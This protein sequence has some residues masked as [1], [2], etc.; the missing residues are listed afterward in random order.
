MGRLAAA[1]LGAVIAYLAFV[2]GHVSPWWLA[3]PICMFAWLVFIHERVLG[4]CT[5]CRR[6]IAFYERALARLDG[7]WAGKG[8]GGERFRDETHPYALDLDLFGDGSLFE[9]LSTARLR[10]GE[11]TLAGWLLHPAGPDEVRARQAAVAELRQKLDLRERLALLAADVPRGVDLE[12]LVSWGAAP[13]LTVSSWTRAVAFALPAA[14]VITLVGWLS[15]QLPASW[16]AAML[17]LEIGF[18]LWVGSRIEK[19]L[20]PVERRARDLSLFAGILACL[21]RQQFTAPR[22]RQLHEQFYTE[23]LPPSAR[24][25]RLVRLIHLLDARR[26]QLFAIPAFL[27]LWTTHLAFALEAWRKAAGAAIGRWLREVGEFEA[28]LALSAYA[29]ENPGDPFPEVAAD[30]HCF[31]GEGLGHPLLPEATCVRN[32]LCLDGALRMLVVSGSN[33]SGKST[34]LRIVGVNAVLAL[35]GAPVRARRLRLSPLAVGATLRIQ[36]SLQ[37]GRSRFF[38]EITRIRQLVELARGPRPLL[39]LLDELLHG[40]NSNERRIGAEAVLGGLLRL[41]ALGLVTTHDLSLAAIADRL[42]PRAA[43]VH[44]GDQFV[45]GEMTF[46]YRLKPGV[47]QEGNALA[48]MRAV[49]LEVDNPPQA[50]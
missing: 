27:L 15:G 8:Q 43:N 19:V 6:A 36:D 11:D 49:G 41:G 1:G 22:L 46:D 5:H 39:F 34:F 18:G 2:T 47:V 12:R 25:A 13:L 4:A 48:L 21:E 35:A 16:F 29:Y 23:G 45:N 37:S 33:M 26:N 50:N 10:D 3:I 9:L 28:L 31:I 30:G 24:I 44:F 40:T 7:H 14:A 17:L 32:D 38:A 20:E 42:A